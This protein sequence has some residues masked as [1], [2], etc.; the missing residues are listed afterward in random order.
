MMSN[1]KK[2]LTLIMTSVLILS[3]LAACGGGKSNS[4]EPANAAPENASVSQ[5]MDLLESKGWENMEATDWE[6][7]HLTRKD[8][9]EMLDELGKTAEDGEEPPFKSVTMVDDR[10]IEIV[11]DKTQAGGELGAGLMTVLLDPMIRQLYVHSD[12]Y[13]NDEQPLIRFIDT[14]G[15][16]IK[17]SSEPLQTGQA[18]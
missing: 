6:K 7:V 4:S 16:V 17:E 2:S 13:K 10:T 5:G 9:K 1:W 8:F 18:E 11:I 3:T 15:N 12:Y 14:D